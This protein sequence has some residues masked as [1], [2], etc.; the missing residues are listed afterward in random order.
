MIN[1]DRQDKVRVDLYIPLY[2]LLIGRCLPRDNDDNTLVVWWWCC[3]SGDPSLI[4]RLSLNCIC[5]GEVGEKLG[6]SVCQMWGKVGRIE[7]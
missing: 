5:C 1:H 4:L 2:L 6:R 7:S 3:Y